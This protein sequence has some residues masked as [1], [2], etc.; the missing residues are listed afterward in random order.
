MALLNDIVKEGFNLT[1]KLVT[2]SLKVLPI[3]SN[4]SALLKPGVLSMPCCF[5]YLTPSVL[6]L[7]PLSGV[8]F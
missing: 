7:K 1:L 4:S 5:T 6:P 2:P 8:D 3:T